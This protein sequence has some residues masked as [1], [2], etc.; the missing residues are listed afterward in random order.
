M[1]ITIDFE[2][3]GKSKFLPFVR[4]N[5]GGSID[6]PDP[7]LASSLSGDRCRGK[8]GGWSTKFKEE[9]SPTQYI[10]LTSNIAPA[11]PGKTAF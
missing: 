4:Q 7:P 8:G 11:S 9:G 1:D 5:F 2:K 3:L 6:P 10:R